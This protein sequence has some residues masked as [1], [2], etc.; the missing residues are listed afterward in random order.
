MLQAFVLV[1]VQYVVVEREHLGGQLAGKG[2]LHCA[3]G[4]GAAAAHH[5][6]GDEIA[7]R[8]LF[9]RTRNL[10][11]GARRIHRLHEV[12]PELRDGAVDVESGRSDRELAHGV[13]LRI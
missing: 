10:R 13:D 2:A 3:Q 4:V 7:A 8:L 5:H 1:S 12:V 9:G 6:R 11:L